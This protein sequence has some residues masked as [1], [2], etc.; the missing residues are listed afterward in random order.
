VYLDNKGV[1]NVNVSA[2]DFDT[3]GG[4]SLPLA[5]VPQE[6]PWTFDF[7]PDNAGGGYG[8][9]D[10]EIQRIVA[11]RGSL[12]CAGLNFESVDGLAD[13][14]E[15][16]AYIEC[17]YESSICW[18]EDQNDATNMLSDLFQLFWSESW[19]FDSLNSEGSEI[20]L[21]SSSDEDGTQEEFIV[22]ACE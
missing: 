4:S 3:D 6:M 12:G 22:P 5:S 10:V 16:D 9:I 20:R 17:W 8:S 11:E 15:F 18:N 2:G 1:L 21:L 7:S 13:A 14:G 19:S